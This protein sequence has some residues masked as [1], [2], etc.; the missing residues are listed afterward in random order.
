MYFS[1]FCIWLRKKRS[2][3]R[4]R[5]IVFVGYGDGRKI[6]LGAY[7]VKTEREAI[8]EAKKSAVRQCDKNPLKHG[9]PGVLDRTRE[10][11]VSLHL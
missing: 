4:L 2:A 10:G 9:T 6:L 8:S 7:T 5:F 3:Q 11:F 1:N